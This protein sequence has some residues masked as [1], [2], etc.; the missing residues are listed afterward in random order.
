MTPADFDAWLAD[1]IAEGQRHAR[2]RGPAARPA[3]RPLEISALEHGVRADL[4]RAPA[5]APFQI[6]FDNKDA[7]VPHNVAIHKDSPTGE[8]VF[9]GEIF[10]GPGH[11]DLRRARPRRPARTPSSAPSTRT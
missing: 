3:S 6:A 10:N 5:G 8:E 11:A 4:A 7:G 9:K 2:R 1:Q